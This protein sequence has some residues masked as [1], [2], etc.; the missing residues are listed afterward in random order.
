MRLAELLQMNPATT[1]MKHALCA[2][3]TSAM[4]SLTAATKSAVI[5]ALGNLWTVSCTAVQCAARMYRGS[6][7]C[8]EIELIIYNNGRPWFDKRRNRTHLEPQGSI[9]NLHFARAGA[10]EW[11]A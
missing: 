3:P 4:L 9:P 6:F 10:A 7:K 5:N 1:S 11:L 8:L 2:W